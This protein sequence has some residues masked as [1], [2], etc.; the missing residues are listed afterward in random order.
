MSDWKTVTCHD[1][2]ED[3]EPLLETPANVEYLGNVEADDAGVTNKTPDPKSNPWI[4]EEINLLNDEDKV[5]LRR[6]LGIPGAVSIVLGI[7]V[8]SGIFI[9]PAGVVQNSG[10]VGEALIIWTMCGLFST[11]G[12]LC[13]A[14]LGILIPKSGGD[15]TYLLE[16]FGPLWAFMRLWIEMIV[17]RPAGH[18]IIALTMAYY[19]L[20]P[21]YTDGSDPP[22]LAIKLLGMSSIGF[23][24]WINC[25]SV[26]WATRIQTV[27]TIGK[28]AALM[29]IVILGAVEIAKGHVENFRRDAVF[30]D[31]VLDPGK[32]IMA[33][34]AGLWAFSG[35]NE[36]NNVVD[37]VKNPSRNLP[38]SIIL[39]VTSATVLYVA[40][41]V[42]YFTLLSP[43]KMESE[44]ATA[45]LFGD[46]VLGKYSF[47][48]PICVALCCFGG[49]NGSLFTASRFF[50]VGACNGHLPAILAMINVRSTAPI[51]SIVLTSILTV[52]YMVTDDVFALINYTNFVYFFAMGFAILG[53]IVLRIK[54]PRSNHSFKLPLIIPITAVLVCLITGIMSFFQA[55]EESGIGLGV[56]L[57]AV[58]IYYI[59]VVLPK[60]SV[61]KRIIGN[62]EYGTEIRKRRFSSLDKDISVV[63]QEKIV[64]KK[65]LGVIG[66]ISLVVGTMIGSGIFLSPKSILANAESVGASLCC[67][68]GCGVLATLS[69]ISYIELGLMI[70]K[71]GGEYNYLKEAY[72]EAIGFVFAW[73]SIIIS[74]PSSFAIIS[75]GFAQ[76]VTAPFYPGCVPPD[77]AT[78]FAAA[79]CILTIT[80][81]NCFSVKASN[82]IQIFFTAAKLLI[83]AAIIIG[84]FVQIANGN[85]Q[86][87][88]NAFEGTT[89]SA[90]AIALAFYSGL[91]SYDGWNQLNFVTEEIRNPERNFPLTVYIGI[92]M[93]TILYILVNI[94]YFTTMSPAEL[95]ASN[96]VAVTFGDRVFGS[97]AWT[98]PLAVAC[99]TFGAA[100]GS[101]FTGARLTYAAA[102]NG[103]M[104]KILSYISVERI[105]PSPAAMFNAFI[106]LL[107][108]IPNSSTFESLIDYFTFSAWIFYGAT[109][110]SVIVLRY[111]LPDLH[112]PYR[113]F[114]AIPAVC[115][116]CSLYL[117]VA[118]IIDNP[119][120]EYL[121]ATI[122]ILLGF[123]I[124]VP[125]IYY[126]KHLPF[127]KSLTIFL[128]Q[129]L[130]VVPPSL[131]EIGLKD[132]DGD[133][134]AD[135]HNYQE[136]KF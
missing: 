124:Y 97:F 125:V 109:F 119:A 50:F 136:Q 17:V 121:Y 36:L 45:V 90:S 92:P 107:M 115:T 104:A 62:M 73:T 30:K 25:S 21:F 23:L 86:Y 81:V 108:I 19:A 87:L 51:S 12:A 33:V 18:A 99:S 67:W 88:T 83:I 122:F 55:P 37:E 13:F 64:L 1:E 57:S 3:I 53:L 71:S 5:K 94:A 79:I 28:V 47:I 54:N 8:G 102:R 58:P 134:H 38:I 15:Y 70:K 93:V 41:N 113:V 72:G 130:E 29:L 14:E 120:L 46:L 112:R 110:A 24:T 40:V 128:Q 132:E 7:I 9:S 91:W 131:D 42:S 77:S 89:T 78:K 95:L 135:F 118:P 106:A 111:R 56:V 34:Y 75:I 11:I 63:K 66:G 101:A 26:K 48:I 127:M 4:T 52:L 96:A 76:Y 100:N 31:S 2:F 43:S 123:V 84:G 6:T 39:S 49:I 105:T 20:Y 10:S 117:I 80:T 116:L 68:A 65:E 32:I 44:E 61:L 103:H 16:I 60:H 126:K 114:I 133:D 98:V 35:W 59:F 69:A 129:L 82:F 85:T 22:S 74:K 27:F